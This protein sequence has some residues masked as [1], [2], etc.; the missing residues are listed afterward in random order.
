MPDP[1]S[2][3][4][5]I[6]PLLNPDGVARGHYR[7]D[8]RGQNLN[9][10]Y[11]NPCPSRHPSIFASMSVLRA[12]NEERGTEGVLFFFDLHAFAVRPG[13]YLIGNTLTPEL[14]AEQWLLAN[15]RVPSLRRRLRALL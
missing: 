9:R 11:N 3:V 13:C 8:A 1:R 7:S 15:V 12:L 2:F 5:K 10:C 14:Q 6:I 4:F